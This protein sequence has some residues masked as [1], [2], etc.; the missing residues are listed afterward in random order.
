MKVTFFIG[1]LYGGGAERVVCNIA[2]YLY[3]KNKEVEIII[4]SS[5]KKTYNLDE[6]ISIYSLLPS[7]YEKTKILKNIIRIFRLVCYLM[8][9]RC[10]TYVVMLPI[11]TILLLKFRKLI[12]GRVIVSERAEPRRYSSK[13]QNLLKK[14]CN[15]ANLYIFQTEDVKDWYLNNGL[16]INYCIIPNAINE[17]FLTYDKNIK[18]DK[19]II[20]I[21]RLTKQKNFELLINAFEKIKDEYSDYELII[22][23]DGEE[24]DS[25][26]KLIDSK[27][28]SN[29]V[30]LAGNV[31]NIKSEIEKA[32]IYVLSS[33]YE[34]MPNALMESMAL[35]LKC[36]AT[37]CAGGGARYLIR[38]NENGILIPI[39]EVD[40]LRNAIIE[41]ISNEK[42]S[43]LMSENA[44][45]II[46]VLHPEIIYKRWLNC[47]EN[48]NGEDNEYK[49]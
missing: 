36:I 8:K 41:M 16:K 4:V 37:D 10:N 23:G 44:K 19:R 39:G 13:N 42:K 7:K 43:K 28:M 38:N 34:G 17:N 48:G 14:Y 18:K 22:Y 25:L 26:T 1:S 11:P 46:D 21:G 24:K 30:T 15:R 45:K 47:I 20:G 49:I 33:D 5:D 32:E 35:G 31:D 2:N 9:N 40:S 12:K 27:K 3:S 29:R 6:H